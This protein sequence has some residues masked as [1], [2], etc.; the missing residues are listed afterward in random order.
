MKK[1]KQFSNFTLIELLIVIA[2]IAILASMLLPALNKARLVAQSSFCASNL[3]Q[4]GL[5]SS[6]Y[7]SDNNEWC[8]YSYYGTDKYGAPLSTTTWIWKLS[9][10]G[11]GYVPNDKSLFCPSEAASSAIW[12]T[13]ANWNSFWG[14]YAS[15]GLRYFGF[16]SVAN[17]STSLPGA[18]RLSVINR[19]GPASKNIQVVDSM[20]RGTSGNTNAEPWNIYQYAY[21]YQKLY[22]STHLRHSLQANALFLDGH[23]GKLRYPVDYS[24]SAL[25]LGWSPYWNNGTLRKY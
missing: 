21:P 14:V 17:A 22:G 11:W 13:G 24:G 3:K 12:K 19:F 20:P 2:I 25:T 16:G 8:F 1:Q 9:S 15:Y 10:R 5:A 6:Y 18:V 23:V 7:N 4:I